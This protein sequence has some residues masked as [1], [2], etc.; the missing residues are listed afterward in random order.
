[1][2]EQQVDAAEEYEFEE[3]SHHY[4]ALNEENEPVATARWRKTTGG[5]KLERFAVLKE[6]RD[7][8]A[9]RELVSHILEVLKNDPP[10]GDIYLHAQIQVIPFYEKAGFKALGDEFTEANI[11]HRKMVYLG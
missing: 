5:V 1:V 2:E 6:Y 11:R 9:G 7:K 8:G 4:L 3:E 10:K